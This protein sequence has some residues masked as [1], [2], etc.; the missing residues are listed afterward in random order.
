MLPSSVATSAAV[1]AKY[2][3][4]RTLMMASEL[5]FDARI[6]TSFTLLTEPTTSPTEKWRNEN[7]FIVIVTSPWK[8]GAMK[9]LL[10]LLLRAHRKTAQ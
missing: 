1:G 8:N 6:W 7:A 9:M 5:P 2:A 10:L 4:F 3:D